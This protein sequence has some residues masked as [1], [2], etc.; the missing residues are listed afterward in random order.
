M[1]VNLKQ[2]DDGLHIISCLTVK[3]VSENYNVP[4]RHYGILDIGNTAGLS[5]I[6]D[7]PPM[8][9]HQT[10]P[11]IEMREFDFAD[12]WEFQETISGVQGAV[13]RLRKAFKDYEYDLVLNNCEQFVNYIKSGEKRSSQIEVAAVVGGTA[14]AGFVGYKLLKG[15]AQLLGRLVGR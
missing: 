15:M 7:A 14:V 6:V 5:L 13:I 2:L 3:E 4:I 9:I 8:L 10:P 12:C 1:P 11:E